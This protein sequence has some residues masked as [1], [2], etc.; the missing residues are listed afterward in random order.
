MASFYTGYNIVLVAGQS[1]ACGNSVTVDADN[2]HNDA[3][4]GL[5]IYVLRAGSDLNYW[6]DRPGVGVPV[7]RHAAGACGRETE[8]QSQRLVF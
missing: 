1:N 6:T 5:P 4:T 2:E 8:S 7:G 3:T